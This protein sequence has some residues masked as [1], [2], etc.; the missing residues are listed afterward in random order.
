[1]M[2]M[3]M[4]KKGMFLKFVVIICALILLSCSRLDKE[5]QKEI[6]LARVGDKTI[7][8]N[9]FI[10]RAEY[11]IRPSYCKG[12]NNIHKKIILNSLVAEKMLALEAGETNELVKNR[13][14]QNYIQGRQEQAM[15]E[16]L[17]HKEGFQKVRLEES[18]IREVYDVVGRTYNVQYIQIPDDS[19]AGIVKEELHNNE[20]LFEA[21]HQQL[22]GA[23]DIPVREVS[24]Q[25]KE[26]PMVHEAIF[27]NCLTKGQVIGPL[28]IDEDNHIVMKVLGWTDQLAITESEQQQRWNDVKEKL[29]EKRAME[30]YDKYVG[31]IMGGKK[32][33]FDQNTFYKMVKLI[34]PLYMRS[35]EE[36]RD[37][38][39]RNAF[40]RDK[41]NT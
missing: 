10:R 23:K 13:Q 30:N 9:E 31:K 8:L 28:R 38:F 19:I 15:R 16:W 2:S 14:F 29:R 4:M 22:W 25:S 1:M 24:W 27:S 41:E 33:E 20:K 37:L 34:S 11:T 32:L 40:N 12:D 17:L 7:S 5:E 39:L 21:T 6:I 36:N 18:E 3:Q 35:P 26:H